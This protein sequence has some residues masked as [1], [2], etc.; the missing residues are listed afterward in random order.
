MP[1]MVA[2][3]IAQEVWAGKLRLRAEPAAWFAGAV[4][5]HGLWWSC[6]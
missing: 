3:E 2:V 4:E 5:E 1:A 6:L